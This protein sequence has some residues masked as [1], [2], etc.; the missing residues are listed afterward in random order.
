[1]ETIKTQS[2]VAEIELVYRP[3]IDVMKARK[4]SSSNCAYQIF[5]E[6]WGEDK[7]QFVESFKIIL[8]EIYFQVPRMKDLP[9]D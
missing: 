3:K 7:I 6:V 2:Q 4:V 9:R 8:V 5:K 1:M